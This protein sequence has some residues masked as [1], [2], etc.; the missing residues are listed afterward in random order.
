SGYRYWAGRG[1]VV[2]VNDPLDTV[3]Q[4]ARAYDIRW[5]ILEADDTV[6]AAKEILVDGKRPDWVGA[7]ILQTRDV[8]VYPL[9]L[10][11]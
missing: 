5:L 11:P 9:A 7:P 4:V 2:L 1:G 10:A 3:E 8:G 6:P